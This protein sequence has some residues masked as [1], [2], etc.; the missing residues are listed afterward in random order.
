[1]TDFQR[2]MLLFV[3]TLAVFQLAKPFVTRR[4]QTLRKR[5]CLYKDQWDCSIYLN[6]ITTK[7]DKRFYTLSGMSKGSFSQ[8]IERRHMKLLIDKFRTLRDDIETG[9][10]RVGNP[11]RA[12]LDGPEGHPALFGRQYTVFKRYGF[13]SYLSAKNEQRYHAYLFDIFICDEA[14]GHFALLKL[15]GDPEFVRLIRLSLADVRKLCDEVL[16]TFAADF[17]EA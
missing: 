6:E 11:D 4:A 14:A 17:A 3:A 8:R 9:A 16:G 7:K 1:M 5:V 2:A 10:Y 15:H 12:I 13:V